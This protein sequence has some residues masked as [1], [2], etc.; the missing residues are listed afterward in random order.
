M[1][2]FFNGVSNYEKRRIR[3][4]LRIEDFE[5]TELLIGIT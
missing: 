1:V 4:R 2:V 3:K 5:G